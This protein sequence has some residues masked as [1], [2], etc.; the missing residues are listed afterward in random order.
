MLHVHRRRAWERTNGFGRRDACNAVIH[1]ALHT[2][3]P[4]SFEQFHDPDWH[5]HGAIDHPPLRP[6]HSKLLNQPLHRRLMDARFARAPFPPQYRLN[7]F[8]CFSQFEATATRMRIHNP[9]PNPVEEL[10]A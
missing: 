6:A 5:N 7:A 4:I 3:F 2:G 9:F 8:D 1:D 10:T